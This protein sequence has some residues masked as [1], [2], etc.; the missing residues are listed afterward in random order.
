MMHTNTK[1]GDRI[2]KSMVFLDGDE[3]WD[4]HPKPSRTKRVLR[5]GGL[6]GLMDR[7]HMQSISSRGYHHSHRWEGHPDSRISEAHFTREELN[8]NPACLPP[9]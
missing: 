4:R 8:N 7:E 1:C 9:M 5:E 3:D 6:D 2:E